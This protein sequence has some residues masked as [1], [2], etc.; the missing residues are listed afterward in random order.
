MILS[1]LIRSALSLSTP[2]LLLLCRFFFFFPSASSINNVKMSQGKKK[3]KEKD[4]N[5][6]P[7]LIFST[8][9]LSPTQLCVKNGARTTG[10]TS[11]WVLNSLL[12]L[13]FIFFLFF[14]F[15]CLRFL[16]LC[17]MGFWWFFM[18]LNMGNLMSLGFRF[19][20]SL[21]KEERKSDGRDE[22]WERWRERN[23][24][25]IKCKAT[26]SVHICTV[27]VA[28][29]QIRTILETLMW[30]IFEAKCV[31]FVSFCI[32]Q[33]FTSADA[34]ALMWSYWRMKA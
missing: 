1:F 28:N 18:D 24:K 8:Q 3:S 9:N 34:D 32:V 5:P 6:F 26:V 30:S 4:E 7:S 31:K 25:K 22:D 23:I 29:V 13:H 2:L 21:T 15:F 20:M 33:R 14:F 27:T 19:R 12:L 16:L 17:N 10:H 11:K